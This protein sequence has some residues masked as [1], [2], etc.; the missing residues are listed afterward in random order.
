MNIKTKI[1]LGAALGALLSVAGVAG[2][3]TYTAEKTAD[4]SLEELEKQALISNR[5]AKKTQV[6]DYFKTIFGQLKTFSQNRMIIEATTEFTNAYDMVNE[7]IALAEADPA[8][9]QTPNYSKLREYYAGPFTEKFKELN[10][11]EDPVALNYYQ[12]LD[13][14]G[15][16]LQDLYIAQNSNPLGSKD[17]LL[18]ANDSSLYTA[19]HRKYH[20]SIRTFLNEFGYYDIFLVNNKGDV[21]RD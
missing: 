4:A 21:L 17:A 9:A 14:R 19:A 13:K 1:I 7:E 5:N 6:E 15:L 16:K 8:T 12:A 11:G 10:N 2:M 3:I 18:A 20:P